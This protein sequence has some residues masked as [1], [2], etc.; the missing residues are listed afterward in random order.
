MDPDLFLTIGIVLAVLSLP[1]LLSAWTDGRAP[2]MGAVM[3]I[4]AGA[5]VVAALTQ[6]PG[7]YGWGDVPRVMLQVLGRYIG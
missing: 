1:S 3:L 2:R 5:L 4:V 6:K 7:G